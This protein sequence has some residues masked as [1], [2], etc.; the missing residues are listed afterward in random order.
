MAGI[1]ING[2]QVLV[3]IN[4][5]F[6]KT[7]KVGTKTVQEQEEYKPGHLMWAHHKPYYFAIGFTD[8][9]GKWKSIS[10]KAWSRPDRKKPK[11]LKVNGHT[12][13]LD[14]SKSFYETGEPV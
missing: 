3:K 13:I 6:P 9:S 5:T 11:E 1:L 7:I 14:L 10:T 2:K 12:Y 4:G 8:S